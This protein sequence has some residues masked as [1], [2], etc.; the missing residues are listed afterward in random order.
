MK[1][2]LIALCALALV[3]MLFVPTS[4]SAQNAY[5]VNDKVISAGV[6]LGNVVGFYGTTSFPP[7]FVQFEMGLPLE[8]LKNKLT[9][10]G[11]IGYAASS[12]DYYWAKY[13]Y[14]Y[15][16]IGVGGN[17]H[18]L[19][20]NA[21]IDAFAGLGLGYT[22]S[23]YSASYKEGY[24]EASQY[25]YSYGGGYFAYDIHVGG[26]YYFTPKLAVLAELGYGFGLFRFGVSYK[27]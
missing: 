23:N 5:N 21:K 8:E 27:I 18:F 17:Y 14:S 11:V 22:I 19:E 26:R 10:G 7:L 1:H 4:A 24:T 2:A 3:A 25:A 12:E 9:I 16:F 6:G 15:I 13:T 20:K